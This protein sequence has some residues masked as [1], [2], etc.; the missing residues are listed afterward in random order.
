MAFGGFDSGAE[1]MYFQL[2]AAGAARGW[3]VVLF[4][5]PG[6]T[7]CMRRN[8]TM[9]YRPDYEAPVGAV[10][11]DVGTRLGAAPAASWPWPG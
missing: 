9:T 6:Q 11:D 4:D 8:P 3:Q 2:G 5:G 1:E 10:L 7:G